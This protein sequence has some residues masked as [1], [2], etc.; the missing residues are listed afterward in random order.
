[1]G[2]EGEEVISFERL[3]DCVHTYVC[4][5][6]YDCGWVDVWRVLLHVKSTYVTVYSCL[7]YTCCV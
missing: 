5:Y 2:W 4:T 1:M 6:V 7:R 3:Q